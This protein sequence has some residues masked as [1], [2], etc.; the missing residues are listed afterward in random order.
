MDRFL[1]CDVGSHMSSYGILDGIIVLMVSLP[2]HWNLVTINVLRLYVRSLGHP[3]GLVA[4][5]LD[6]TLKFENHC[7]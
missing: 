2:G 3:K 5:L 1:P 4:E 6:G 7:V